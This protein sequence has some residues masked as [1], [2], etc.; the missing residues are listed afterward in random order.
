MN[1]EVESWLVGRRD[2]EEVNCELDAGLLAGDTPHLPPVSTLAGFMFE[3]W[4]PVSRVSKI[5]ETQ[6]RILVAVSL[7]QPSP[8]LMKAAASAA[9]ESSLCPGFST[10]ASK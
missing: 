2:V 6:I 7:K 9:H 5:T 10:F 1:G 4:A 3:C 8:R